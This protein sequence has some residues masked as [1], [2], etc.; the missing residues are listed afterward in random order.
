MAFGAMAAQNALATSSAETRSGFAT[1][2]LTIDATV[3][4]IPQK[5]PDREIALLMIPCP[6]V[7][8]L[9][10]VSGWTETEGSVIPAHPERIESASTAGRIFFTV[11][12]FVMP[13]P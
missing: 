9:I 3:G 2:I 8:G 4:P 12:S 7:V 13:P 1:N 10:G 5:V 11:Y 6:G